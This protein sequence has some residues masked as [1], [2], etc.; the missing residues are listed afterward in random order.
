MNEKLKFA[1]VHFDYDTFIKLVT[2]ENINSRDQD[3]YDVFHLFVAYGYDQLDSD[4]SIVEIKMMKQLLAMKAT[5]NTRCADDRT[6]LYQAILRQA[7]PI[8][9]FLLE[10]KADMR[11]ECSGD[12]TPIRQACI[13]EHDG[14]SFPMCRMLMMC[15]AKL[16]EFEI[17][18][19]NQTRCY[20]PNEAMKQF[21]RQ[22]EASK[23]STLAFLSSDKKSYLLKL[24]GKDILKYIAELVWETRGRP[25][26]GR[27]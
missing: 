12:R 13:K 5:V 22:I 26:W 6:P 1:A 27:E 18:N 3:G 23:K 9:A 21:S 11:V 16:E 8:V 14:E 24:V 15:G 10:N 19:G 2:P 4:N 7:D 25:E 20:G 17:E